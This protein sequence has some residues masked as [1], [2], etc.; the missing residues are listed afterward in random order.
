[1][2]I[3][4]QDIQALAHPLTSPVFPRFTP[5]EALVLNLIASAHPQPIPRDEILRRLRYAGLRSHWG[6]PTLQ[7]LQVAIVSIR[8]K[9]GERKNHASR[10]ISVYSMTER[11]T[12]GSLIG[13]A[14]KG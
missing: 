7:S 11:G 6:G 1:M 5:Q 4:T 2:T 10:L 12:R 3:Q 8:A 14:W 13:Y 9:L